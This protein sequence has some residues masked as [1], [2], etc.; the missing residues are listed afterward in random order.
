MSARNLVIKKIFKL[1][2]FTTTIFALGSVLFSLEQKKFTSNLEERESL[3]ALTFSL[4]LDKVVFNQELKNIKIECEKKINLI[5]CKQLATLL[6][7]SRNRAKDYKT[8]LTNTLDLSEKDNFVKELV[9]YEKRFNKITKKTFGLSFSEAKS[10]GI[11]SIEDFINISKNEGDLDQIKNKDLDKTL[12]KIKNQINQMISFLEN[13]FL[14]NE[15]FSN[16]PNIYINLNKLFYFLIV[17]E[18]GLFLLVN[19]M[20]IIN[21]NADPQKENEFNLKNIQQKVKPLTIS[22][23]FTFILMICGQFLLKKEANSEYIAH[24]R[25]LNQQNINFLNTVKAYPDLDLSKQ[26]KYINSP[27]YCDKFIDEND[28]NEINRLSEITSKNP[29]LNQEFQAFKATKLADNYQ[30][31]TQNQSEISRNL[32]FAML[33]LNVTSLAFLALHLKIDSEDIG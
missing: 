7:K 6:T 4:K 29:S 30:E 12:F 15:K 17:S 3:N 13:D 20:D 5:D 16:I 32:L 23:L 33:I 21:N 9:N 11:L 2:I 18:I 8:L 27:I 28:Q 19:L 10:K 31:K 26:L 1:V 24:C 25:R 22:V 14:N